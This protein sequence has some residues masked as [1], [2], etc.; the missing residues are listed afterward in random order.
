MTG[1]YL[2]GM[3]ER[4]WVRVIFVSSE[5][6][7]QIPA[8]MIHYGMTKTAQLAIARGVAE[9]FPASGVTVNPVLA[10]PT[11]SEGVDTF[12][13][14]LAKL[15]GESKENVVR[16]FFEHARPTSLLKRFATTEEVASMIVYLCSAAA[17]ST[18]GA[19]LRVDGGVLRSIA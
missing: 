16:D 3:L 17:S 2:P 1:H 5:S 8:E 19:A 12:I 15:R 7:L 18:M 4:K 6:A 14:S 10:G 9:S 11:E 13:E